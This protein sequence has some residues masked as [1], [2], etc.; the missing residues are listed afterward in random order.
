[1]KPQETL[2]GLKKKVRGVTSIEESDQFWVQKE[3]I[4]KNEDLL[5]DFKG[6]ET[7]FLFHN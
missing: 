5:N 7:I 6:N 2:E 4:L 1:M 3:C